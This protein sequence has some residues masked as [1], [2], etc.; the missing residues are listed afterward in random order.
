MEA[1]KIA[2]S[3]RNFLALLLVVIGFALRLLPH[4]PNFAPVGALALFAGAVLGWQAG[5]LLPL[6]IMVS[7]D[8]VIGLY[9]GV[10]FTW[11][12]FVLVGLFGLSLKNRH[13][14]VQ[15]AAGAL[16][17]GLIFFIVSNFGVWAS[18]GMYPLS[19]QGLLACYS[20]AIPFLRM[21]LTAD[22]VYSLALFGLYAAALWLAQHWV[23]LSSRYPD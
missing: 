19:W 11:L 22:F 8:I 18:S 23:P 17:S 15:V 20:A 4:A 5:L 2:V 1:R 13:V 14:S 16:G 7:S 21:S 10:Y 9:P 3:Q 12:G 6:A